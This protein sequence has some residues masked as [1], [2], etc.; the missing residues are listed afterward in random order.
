MI[1]LD[2]H[3]AYWLLFDDKKIPE[4]IKDIID[5]QEDEI[6]LSTISL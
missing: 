4:Y 3:V 2:T 1:L 5:S 6:Y